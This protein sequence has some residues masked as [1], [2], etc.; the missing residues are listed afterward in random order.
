M[1]P[2]MKGECVTVEVSRDDLPAVMTAARDDERLDLKY[3]RCLSG[4]D[5]QE[6]GWKSSTTSGRSRRS[7]AC[8]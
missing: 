4:V 6:E 7:T 3:L 5:W 8:R 2:E 1:V